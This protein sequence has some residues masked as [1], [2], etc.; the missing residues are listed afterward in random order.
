MLMR[1]EYL[2]TLEG[3][4]YLKYEYY[5]KEKTFQE[6]AENF[7][8]N[9]TFISRVFKKYGLTPNNKSEA[10]KISLKKGIASHPTK[11]KKREYL[12]KD[13]IAKTMKKMWAERS[14]EEIQKIK[15]KARENLLSVPIEK[16]EKYYKKSSE[17]NRKNGIEGSRLEKFISKFLILNKYKLELH[18]KQ[19]I[20]NEEM[21]LDIFL[22]EQGIAIEIDGAHHFKDIY[23]EE[24]L[25]KR[26]TQDNVKNWL[27][28]S[29]GYFMIRVQFPGDYI[30]NIDLKK[31][32]SQLLKLIQFITT[33]S[34]EEAKKFE[35]LEN[36]IF[37]IKGNKG[38]NNE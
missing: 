16:R 5:T 2:S 27:V 25:R 37:I 24:K 6:I 15:D 21:H 11:G 31:C 7:G 22:P 12:V 20:E 34:E 32:S 4:E 13:K 26:E 36:R 9:K 29:A 33:M 14:P 1:K 38:K 18:K 8:T 19:L 28:V 35:N 30:S 10:Q 23:G 17:T 3:L